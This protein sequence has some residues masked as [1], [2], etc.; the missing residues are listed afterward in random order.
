MRNEILADTTPVPFFGD[1]ENAKTISLGINP[2]SNEFP[3]SM[4][5]LSHLS[6]FNFPIDYYRQGLKGMTINHA[7]EI[8][9]SLLNYFEA[10]VNGKP[11][12]YHEWFDLAEI[13]LN[14]VGATYFKT[15]SKNN[16]LNIACHLDIFPWSTRSHS[17]LDKAIK[18]E[19]YKENFNFF[20]SYL[21]SENIDEVL[22]L[23]STVKNILIDIFKQ[24]KLQINFKAE[25]FTGSMAQYEYGII[26]IGNKSLQY[27]LLSKG[28]SAQFITDENKKYIHQDFSDWIKSKH[29]LN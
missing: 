8:S 17:H 12:Y 9:R 2:S 24:Q 14:G 15:K 5:R 10:S 16:N 3:N 28:P 29:L 19:F 18:K 20:Y 25:T 7:I 21:Q 1:F 22:I 11:T 27:S 23:G 26:Q 13:A 6:D 4:R